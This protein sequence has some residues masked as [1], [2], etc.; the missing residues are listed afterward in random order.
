MCTDRSN[1]EDAIGKAGK[2]VLSGDEFSYDATSVRMWLKE[3]RILRNSTTQG[4]SRCPGLSVDEECAR[5]L[6][7]GTEMATGTVKWFSDKKGYGFIRR[8][9]EEDL[10]VH[11]TGINGTGFKSLAEGQEVSFEISRGE[12]GPL[13]T[14]VEV[15]GGVG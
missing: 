14:N 3:L 9:G 5:I 13:A 10:F 15:V 4:A 12:K 6:V 7:R 11:H 8:E 2:C 1:L